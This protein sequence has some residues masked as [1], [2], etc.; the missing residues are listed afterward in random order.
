[1]PRETLTRSV[2]LIDTT[3]GD[4]FWK[5]SAKDSGASGGGANMPA[6]DTWVS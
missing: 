1:M 2:T 6:V 4:T 3:A 5:M